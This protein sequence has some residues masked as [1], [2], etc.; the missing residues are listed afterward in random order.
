MNGFAT[1]FKILSARK[2]AHNRGID[3]DRNQTQA[4]SIMSSLRLYPCASVPFFFGASN[5]DALWQM[6]DIFDQMMIQKRQSAF[7]AVS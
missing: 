3:S 4:R 5:L 6:I 7:D 2:T 1:S